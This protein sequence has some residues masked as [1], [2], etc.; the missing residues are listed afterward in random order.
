MTN[1]ATTLNSAGQL[2]AAIP[3]LLGYYPTD[4]IVVL[5]LNDHNLAFTLRTDC[6]A[7]PTL[8]P[9]LAVNLVREINRRKD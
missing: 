3:H 9:L 1:H 5:A 2:I 7:E 6:P 4:S 8:Y